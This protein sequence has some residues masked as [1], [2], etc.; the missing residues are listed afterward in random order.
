MISL[1]ALLLGGCPAHAPRAADSFGASLSAADE[2]WSARAASGGVDAAESAYAALFG[3][4]PESAELLWR[5]SRAAWSR[6]LID[7]D[8]AQTWHEVGRE[9]AMRCVMTDPGVAATVAK[10]GDRLD[11]AMLA[12]ATLPSECLVFAGAHVVA[13]VEARGAGA[14]LDLEDSEP[15]LAMAA[16]D[17]TAEPAAREWAAGRWLTLSGVTPDAARAH[18]LAAATLA[19][20][21]RFYRDAALQSFPDLADTLAPFTPEPAWALENHEAR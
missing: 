11:N 9:Y 8:N 10:R 2:V 7:P 3:M 1:L 13:L 17:T 15:L 20:G 12:S 4:R 16:P 18:L 21:V 6:A 19:P 5:L 14:R